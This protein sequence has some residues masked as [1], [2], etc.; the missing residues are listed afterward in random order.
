MRQTI[1]GNCCPHRCPPGQS[2]YL[3]PPADGARA[4]RGPDTETFRPRPVERSWCHRL[5]LAVL[6]AGLTSDAIGLTSP[7]PRSAALKAKQPL[8]T[9]LD[10]GHAAQLQGYVSGRHRPGV[11]STRSAEP[12]PTG[13]RHAPPNGSGR[14]RTGTLRPATTAGRS[15]ALGGPATSPRPALPCSATLTP[16]ADRPPSSMPL[17]EPSPSAS[18]CAMTSRPRAPCA[19]RHRERNPPAS[20]PLS[21]LPRVPAASRRSTATGSTRKATFRPFRRW[22]GRTPPGLGRGFLR[23]RRGRGR[24]R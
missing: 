15:G 9:A 8:G 23:G 21:V 22:L 11:F 18:R 6:L 2:P 4:P 20:K 5:H 14:E 19:Q 16:N 24:A 17:L 13:A 3:R 1:A 7:A 12:R 10:D